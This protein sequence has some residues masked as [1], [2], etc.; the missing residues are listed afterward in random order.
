M[1]CVRIF[2]QNILSRQFWK[3]WVE[4]TVTCLP[5]HWKHRLLLPCT[6][7]APDSWDRWRPLPALPNLAGKPSQAFLFSC[8]S[9]PAWM[10]HSTL[11]R[12]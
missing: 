6:L 2:F 5:P 10:G 7:A 1:V 4:T 9:F 8:L 3:W 11:L 12:R